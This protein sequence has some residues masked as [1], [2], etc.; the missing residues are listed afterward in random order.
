MKATLADIQID[1]TSAMMDDIDSALPHIAKAARGTNASSFG[2]YR[3]A[4]ILHLTEFIAHDHEVLHSY[5]GDVSFAKMARD[6][7]AAHPSKKASARWF[8]EHLPEFLKTYKP[9]AHHPEIQEL[10]QLEAALNFAFDAP[11]A[12]SLTL[13][14]MAAMEPRTFTT[15]ALSMHPSAVRLTFLQNTTSIWS[16]LKCEEQPP[17]PHRL[18][19]PQQLAVWRQGTTSRFRMLGDEEAMAFDSTYTGANFNVICEMIALMEGADTAAMR[20]ASYLRG[21]VEAELVLVP[22]PATVPTPEA[23]LKK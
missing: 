14:G 18:N 21:W 16:A 17:K 1:L 15:M 2:I 23:V 11:E 9:F 10:A 5:L 22:A 19:A 4:Y 12:D 3:D 20:A 8:C 6:Y 13:A 7:I